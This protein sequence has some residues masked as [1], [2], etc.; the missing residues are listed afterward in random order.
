[1]INVAL[2]AR[3]G[4]SLVEL[5]ISLVLTAIVGVALTSLFVTQAGFLD[6]QQKAA[7]ARGVARSATNIM[8]SELRMIE[9][10]SG[11]TAASDT[12]ITVRVPYAMGIVCATTATLITLSML[13][14]DSVMF[15][16][17]TIGGFAYRKADGAYTYVATTTIPALAATS[18]ACSTAGITVVTGGVKRTIATTAL[19]PAP[20][21]APVLLY[22][23]VRYHFGNSAAVSGRKGLFRAVPAASIDEEIVAPFDTSAR[24]KFYVNDAK[25]SQTAAPANL[26]TL[27]GLDL[28]LNSVSERPTNGVYTVVKS[29]TA[30]FFKNRRT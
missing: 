10:D 2:K 27:T 12:S 7:Y 8:M 25:T 17:A 18:T 4:F 15:A 9:R 5:L 11:V 20:I 26:R 30:V 28:I 19:H 13:P 6:R 1:M 3:R 24:F 14:V 16:D 29:N 22:Q 23:T 21:G